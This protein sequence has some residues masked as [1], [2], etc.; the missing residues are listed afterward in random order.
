MF[1]SSLIGNVYNI[2][3]GF[4]VVALRLYWIEREAEHDSSLV[5]IFLIAT[6][7]ADTPTL[8]PSGNNV[9]NFTHLVF[10]LLGF[11]TLLGDVLYILRDQ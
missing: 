11:V 9:L 2:K 6:V 8:L 5:C 3:T 1:F 7:L 10:P 4:V